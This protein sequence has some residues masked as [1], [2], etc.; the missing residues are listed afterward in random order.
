M[1]ALIEAVGF[2][3]AA[4]DLNTGETVDSFGVSIN[5]HQPENAI[6][7]VDFLAFRRRSCS[8]YSRLAPKLTSSAA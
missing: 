2:G 5:N 8:R 7:L 3:I 6:K 1:S 4:L